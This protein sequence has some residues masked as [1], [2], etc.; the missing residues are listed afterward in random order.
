MKRVKGYSHIHKPLNTIIPN[1]VDTQTRNYASRSHENNYFK[2]VVKRNGDRAKTMV[3]IEPRFT[4][5]DINEI[6]HKAYGE[7]KKQA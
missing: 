5:Q 1:T 7:T 2:S 3:F 6:S 4:D